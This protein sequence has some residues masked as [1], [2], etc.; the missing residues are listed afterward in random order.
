MQTSC[1]RQIALQC[2]KMGIVHAQELLEWTCLE[3]KFCAPAIW[4][5]C[6]AKVFTVSAKA[7]VPESE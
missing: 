1:Q 4:L 6:T 3:R 5:L 7:L 2:K